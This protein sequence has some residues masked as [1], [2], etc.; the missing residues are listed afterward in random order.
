MTEAYLPPENPPEGYE[1]ISYPVGD[2]HPVTLTPRV[3]RSLDVHHVGVAVR[4]IDEAMRFYGDTLGLRMVDRRHLADRQ[5]DVAFVQAGSTL[6]ELLEAT[7]ASTPVARFIERRGPGLHHL[8]FGTTDID[9]HL[10][11]LGRAGVQLI[12]EEA[13]PGAH[14]RV[15]FLHPD[16]THGALV[17]LIEAGMVERTMQGESA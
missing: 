7:D 3:H 17:E 1:P 11:D 14:G 10:R 2:S 15:A 13:R 12:D 8:C 5:L 16:S 4:S 6:I 9:Q